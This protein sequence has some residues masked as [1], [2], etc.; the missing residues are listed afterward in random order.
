M[1]ALRRVA[2]LLSV[3]GASGC[4]TQPAWLAARIAELE[5]LPPAN[6]P[7]EIYR[8]EYQGRVAYLLTPTCCDI[9]A[10]LHEES[11][12]LI[13]YPY[14]GFAGSDPRCPDVTA[15][16]TSAPV[17]RDPRAAKRT[18]GPRAR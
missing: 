6:P 17:W 12:E 10:E 4:A 18:A 16:R 8:L 11:G 5:R 14:G 15:L 1:K 2:L 13:C 9:P 7:R 3:A